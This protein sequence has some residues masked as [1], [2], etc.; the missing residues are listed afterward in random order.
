MVNTNPPGL[1]GA[2]YEFLSKPTHHQIQII[3]AMGIEQ[4]CRIPLYGLNPWLEAFETIKLLKLQE[5]FMYEVERNRS[6][7]RY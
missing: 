5:R 4:N 3:L 6:A 7:D 2:I 1:R